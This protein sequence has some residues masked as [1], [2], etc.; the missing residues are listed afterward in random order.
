VL[1]QGPDPK[2]FF[3]TFPRFGETSETGPWLDRLNARYA[4]LVHSNRELLRDARVLDLA[5]HDGRFTLAALKS[6]AAHVVG[7]EINRRLRDAA[8]KN[9][10]TYDIPRDRYE[11]VLGDM[12]ERIDEVE[13]FDVV[14][15]FGILYHLTDHMVLLSKI[16]AREPRHLIIDTHVSRRE[17][18]V[19]ELRNAFGESPPPPGSYIEGRPTRLALE[20]M[21]SYFG[22]TFRY[23]DWTAS[24]LAE[25]GHVGDY[26]RGERVSLR[27]TCNE[28]VVPAKQRERAVQ[29]ALDAGDDRSSRSIAITQIAPRFGMTP[30]AL[31]FWVTRAERTGAYGY[32]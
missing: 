12:I 18:A 13:P 26:R 17:G 25:S 1:D 3:D 14:F 31:R 23:F 19:I 32:E 28:T 24:G 20:S 9:M 4:A 16:A 11:F 6:G 5:S 22:W 29:L 8:L 15:C 2:R 7:I 10:E 27:V 21:L 30:Q